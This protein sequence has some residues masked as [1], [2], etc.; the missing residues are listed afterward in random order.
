[1]LIFL[2]R[3]FLA[4]VAVLL[5]A[6]ISPAKS[7]D[8]NIWPYTGNQ[9]IYFIENKGQITDQ[10]RNTRKDIQYKTE[11]NGLQIFI[12]AGELHYQ[13]TRD[14][15]AEQ[16]DIHKTELYRLDVMLEGADK[17]VKPVAGQE[18]AYY[19]I[20]YDGNVPEG[21]KL[22]AYKKI[23][24]RN[25]YPN[26][27]WVVYSNGNDLKYD[28][29]VHPGGNINYIKLR[30]SGADQLIT[31]N[32][33]LKVTTPYGTI[34][35][36]KPYSYELHTGKAIASAYVLADKTVRFEV[37]GYKGA[38]VIDPALSWSTYY[39]TDPVVDYGT[40]L[41]TDQ[42][43][44]VYM[45]GTTYSNSN[46]ATVGAH[47]YTFTAQSADVG[48]A[49]IAKFNAGGTRLWATYYGG[50]EKDELAD[51]AVSAT[52]DVYIAG[53]TLSD[54]GIATSGSH[55]PLYGGGVLLKGDIYLA[56]FNT[57]GVRE[58]GTYY[59]G[60]MM[61]HDP[62]LAIDGDNNIYLAGTSSSSNDI[63]TANAHQTALGGGQDGFLAK[64]NDKGQRLWATYC[65]GETYNEEI[66]AITTDRNGNVYIGGFTTSETNISTP[67]VHQEVF[68][69]HNSATITDAFVMK[70]DGNGNKLWGTYYGGVDYD[71][72]EA[73]ACDKN[74]N[75]Y[76][77]GRTLSAD[78]IATA[79][80]YQEDHNNNSDHD[81][82]IA[83]LS[84][85][86]RRVWG[87]YFGGDGFDEVKDLAFNKKGML[88]VAGTTYAQ[89]LATPGSFQAHSNGDADAFLAI[90]NLS[91]QRMYT[92]YFGGNNFDQLISMEPDKR[93]NL[94]IC[95]NTSS[96]TGI[97]TPAAFKSSFSGSSTL[98][99]A[100]LTRFDTDTTVFFDQFFA[101]TNFCVGDTFRVTYN[102]TRPYNA[103][104][105]FTVE[106]SD[107]AGDFSQATV[108][109][110]VNSNTAGSILCYIPGN[111][112]V[113]SK[114]RIRILASN[115]P[116]TSFDNGINLRIGRMPAV[117]A[118]GSSP[119]CEGDTIYLDMDVN[120]PDIVYT[121]QGPN[122]YASDKK[123]TEVIHTNITSSGD[124]IAGAALYGCIAYDTVRVVV[125]AAPDTPVISSNSPVCAGGAILFSA[126]STPGATY[127]WQG[128]NG[129]TSNAQNPF[130]MDI[131]MNAFGVYT[132]VATLNG[133]SSPEASYTAVVKPLPEK[134][135]AY[136]NSPICEGDSLML[137][138]ENTQGGLLYSWAGPGGYTS[139]YENPVI[140]TTDIGNKGIYSL[141]AYLNGCTQSDTAAVHIKPRPKP[142]IVSNSPVW[143]NEEIKLSAGGIQPGSVYYW[144]GPEGF[145]SEKSEVNIPGATESMSGTY[146]V[147]ATYDGCS[148]SGSALV[149]VYKLTD[150]FFVL[151]P[152][153]NNGSFTIQARLIEKQDIPFE[154]V[155]AAGQYIYSEV[156]PGANRAF[157]KKID[158]TGRLASGVYYLRIKLN[159]EIKNIPF[160]VQR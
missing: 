21:L 30:Y 126:S 104:N 150:D 83:K 113:G 147:T 24:Y 106:L 48:D 144:T 6:Y 120:F 115:K 81:G 110:A 141:T 57:N 87:S 98:Y 122:S 51:I 149:L 136:S 18:Q 127:S 124:Y 114:Y 158:L 45:G 4:L 65:G 25:I 69:I 151:F 85:D 118:T 15:T 72:L 12:G 88:Y 137:F 99:D 148:G 91:G 14:I 49:Y 7:N 82:Y 66:E 139:S 79:G 111:A 138:A 61:D 3:S 97:A 123:A 62:K 37:G 22:R 34:T 135:V 160:S 152:N 95:G 5:L 116:D 78:K 70:Y 140:R 89:N 155:T 121:W 93:G 102:V 154:V 10:H 84:P 39:G 103:G 134:P 157:E 52:G 63:I 9:G 13:W 143:D 16:Q 119:I 2:R 11:A 23:I 32:G 56:K 64:F 53:F 73:L 33:A 86:G 101:R 42:K 153:P 71:Y 112:D 27:D 43:G 75:V 46:I 26:I 94:F 1:M 41:G 36:Q 130:I 35:E 74:G 159:E 28:F 31:E 38:V 117:T 145:T 92:T 77:G 8:G 100:F 107:S 58:W 59:G 105:V 96:T 47:K 109:G 146:T 108:I 76:I 60:F 129:F 44:N 54:T 29:V 80:T 20:H 40:A 55:Q 19:E 132:V 50:N 133:C 90:F 125:S 17:N 156:I 131:S 68:H 128:P 67:G 142:V